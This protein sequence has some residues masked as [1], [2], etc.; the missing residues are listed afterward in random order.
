MV[1]EILPVETC[2]QATLEIAINTHA[3]TI[4]VLH[5]VA[6][7]LMMNDSKKI[8]NDDDGYLVPLGSRAYKV[9]SPF[10]YIVDLPNVLAPF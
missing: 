5:V 3:T 2:A 4:V 8:Q 6:P 1:P 10:L 7:L 9:P